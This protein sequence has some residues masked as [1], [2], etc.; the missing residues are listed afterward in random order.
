[1]NID[2]EKIKQIEHEFENLQDKQFEIEL[3]E[4]NG[5]DVN[6]KGNSTDSDKLFEEMESTDVILSDDKSNSEEVSCDAEQEIT[7][8]ECSICEARYATYRECEIHYKAVHPE[9]S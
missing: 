1:M 2:L 7:M 4:E 9:S 5:S 8:Y 6:I 3:S